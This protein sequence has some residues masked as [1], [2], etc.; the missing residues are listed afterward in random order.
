LDRSHSCATRHRR[1][2]I[3]VGDD[4]E[5]CGCAVKGDAG[6]ASQIVAKDFDL[7]SDFPRGGV[8]LYEGSQTGFQRKNRA[9]A[10]QAREGT[11]DIAAHGGCTVE[12][13][14]GC[15]NECR[16]WDVAVRAVGLRTKAKSLSNTQALENLSMKRKHIKPAVTLFRGGSEKGMALWCRL[17]PVFI[18]LKS[19]SPVFAQRFM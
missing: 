13:A 1:F 9:A 15:L 11:V 7:A 12:I 2:D 18:L 5:R 8:W 16:E 14:V 6:G 4:R 3:R 19:L 17:I 10:G